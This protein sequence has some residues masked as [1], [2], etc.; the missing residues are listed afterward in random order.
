ME[1]IARYRYNRR[2]LVKEAS[3]G[4]IQDRVGCLQTAKSVPSTDWTQ[5]GL[6]GIGVFETSPRSSVGKMGA[7]SSVGLECLL[8]M[9]E[10]TGSNPVT[11]TNLKFC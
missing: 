2:P 3:E 7:Y 10:V 4:V 9:Q 1:L 8:D 11:P 6:G 5:D